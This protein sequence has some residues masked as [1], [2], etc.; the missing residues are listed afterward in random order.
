MTMGKSLNNVSKEVRYEIAYLFLMHSMYR[1]THLLGKNLP[2]DL[3][4]TVPVAGYP[5]L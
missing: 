1:V 2:V 5:L 3:V 4:L